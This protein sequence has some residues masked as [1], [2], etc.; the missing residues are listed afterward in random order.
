M[1]SQKN[2]RDKLKKLC[3]HFYTPYDHKISQGG[4]IAQRIPTH[5]LAWT[6]NEGVMWSH[7]EK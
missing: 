5:K 6:L 7:V 4:D 3:L 1:C 2:S